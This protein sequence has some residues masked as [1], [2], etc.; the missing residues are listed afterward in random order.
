M[1]FCRRCG[2]HRTTALCPRAGTMTAMINPSLVFSRPPGPPEKDRL[3]L[4]NGSP[5]RPRRCPDRAQ[6]ERAG[7]RTGRSTSSGRAGRSPPR[8]TRPGPESGSG[9]CR[10]S[11]TAAPAPRSESPARYERMPQVLPQGSDALLKES[12]EA[13]VCVGANVCAC[14]W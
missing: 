9:P 7:V 8:R 13:R 1:S 12:G 5:R 10:T 6:R 14:S 11:G 3:T 2:G 4:A